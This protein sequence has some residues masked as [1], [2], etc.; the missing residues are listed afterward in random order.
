MSGSKSFRRKLNDSF[1]LDDVGSTLLEELAKGL[2]QPEEVLRE[3]IQNAID[4]H[5]MWKKETESEPEAAIQI[6]VQGNKISIIDNGIGMDEQEIKKVKAI[7]V[8]KKRDAD[9]LLTGHKGVGI[10]AGLSYFDSLTL[11]STK[12]GSNL[13]YK[14]TIY[15]KKIVDSINE[16]TNIGEALNPNY[17]IE[18]Y[19]ENIE[20]HY[21]MVTLQGPT[22]AIEFFTDV[23]QIKQ[24]V[25]KNCPCKI[26][27]SFTFND[28]LMDW[29]KENKIEL[30]EITVNG[31]EVFKY[32]PSNITAFKTDVISINDIVVAKCWYAY[33]EEKSGKLPIKPGE[34]LGFQIIQNGFAI[35]IQNLY[36]DDHLVGYE[37][38]KVMSTSLDW[39]VS[40][41]H[42]INKNLRPNLRR[43][44]FEESE[45]TRQFINK[46]RNWYK[47]REAQAKIVSAEFNLK[48]KYNKYEE[49]ITKYNQMKQTE[50][51]EQ[52]ISQLLNEIK[53]SKQELEEHESSVARAKG[54]HDI[55][56]QIAAQR[57]FSAKRNKIIADIQKILAEIEKIANGVSTCEGDPKNQPEEKAQPSPSVSNNEPVYTNVSFSGSGASNHYREGTC[58][59]ATYNDSSEID[60]NSKSDK[61]VLFGIFVGILEAILIEEQLDLKV[62]NAIIEKLNNQIEEVIDNV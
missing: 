22:R 38:I 30:Y 24:T 5:R 62:K 29:H 41:I 11:Y 6:E 56:H 47:D 43:N 15:F 16:N 53:I 54:K 44:Q 51:L 42:V 26:H 25:S 48:K 20:D 36:S 58:N 17:S 61:R 23:T 33:H 19:E 35:G 13:M 57:K 1:S 18:E 8:S 32:Y 46:L 12:Y 60:V 37:A 49:N 59:E 2:Y 34:L 28:K 39:F 27:E 52:E 10:W 9:V 7:A 50:C 21:T 55:G 40:E 14:L 4:A 45:P 3:Y 31:D